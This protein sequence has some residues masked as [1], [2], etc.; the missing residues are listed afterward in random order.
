MS[1]QRLVLTTL[2]FLYSISSASADQ[3]TINSWSLHC[4]QP[5]REQ[6]V[7]LGGIT[8]AIQTDVLIH[9][10]H[11][12]LLQTAAALLELASSLGSPYIS[13]AKEAN[14]KALAQQ[15]P[16]A[17][18]SPPLAN[19]LTA[20]Q[21]AWADEVLTTCIRELQW[22]LTPRLLLSTS[23]LRKLDSIRHQLGEALCRLRRL[24][25]IMAT[26]PSNWSSNELQQLLR[27]PANTSDHLTQR[28]RASRSILALRRAAGGVQE[29]A[30]WFHGARRLG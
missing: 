24:A 6:P 25:D 27:Q 7:R 16:L 17:P 28:T 15:N 19:K 8:Q 3:Q 13:A 14:L 2:V 30:Q 1:T 4:L 23:Q 5:R 10:Q 20:T 9:R 18:S 21:L 29:V 11:Q 22:W 12:R 26:Q